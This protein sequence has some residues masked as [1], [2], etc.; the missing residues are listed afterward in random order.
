MFE[1]LAAVMQ[2]E[3]L[4]LQPSQ[5][6]TIVLSIYFH[7]AIYNPQS[8]SN[9]EDSEK[10]WQEFAKQVNTIPREIVHEVAKFIFATKA[11]KVS[12]DG[13][14]D[15]DD[16]SKLLAFFLD[17][18][19]AV[20]AKQP[21]AYMS[22]AALIRKEYHF[23]PAETYCAKRAEIL[24]DMVHQKRL[25]ASPVFAPWETRARNNLRNE[26]ALLKQGTIPA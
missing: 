20:L 1:Y 19:L 15:Q 23:V 14:G 10:L 22:Y 9:E 4:K 7:D 25:Y 12:D 21:D 26:V 2:Q 3:D 17:L 5:E 6:V 16:D 13:G 8:A 18:D 11:H 24:Q